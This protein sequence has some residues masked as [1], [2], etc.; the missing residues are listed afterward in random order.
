MLRDE[1]APTSQYD[2]KVLSDYYVNGRRYS[3]T[4]KH[5]GFAHF[6]FGVSEKSFLDCFP[7]YVHENLVCEFCSAC[8]LSK[9]V[10]RDSALSA[11]PIELTIKSENLQKVG[12]VVGGGSTSEGAS[13]LGAVVT[14]EGYKVSFPFCV[15]C[16]HQPS[17]FCECKCCKGIE[18]INK[19]KLSGIYSRSL[20]RL[21]DY[22]YALLSPIELMHISAVLVVIAKA[23]PLKDVSYPRTPL[24][25]LEI[26]V[27]AGILERSIGW[28]ENALTMRNTYEY[29]FDSSQL[30][31]SARR[32]NVAEAELVKALDTSSDS[33][34]SK[35]FR[36][37][38]KELW[39]ELA[40]DY[41]NF[42]LERNLKNDEIEFYMTSSFE[43]EIENKILTIGLS[44]AYQ[45]VLD[46]LAN[47]SC[48]RQAIDDNVKGFASV[49]SMLFL[50]MRGLDF[51]KTPVSKFR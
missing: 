29:S 15:N 28:S 6:S 22:N 30:R 17:K 40:L 3:D 1:S 23:A 13:T 20:E 48:S 12:S 24:N 26:L 49:F 8:L 41:L 50:E 45:Y 5:H 18:S 35:R 31:Y 39:C 36:N 19:A 21:F 10:S 51:F 33:T 44:S 14:E 2:A 42:E 47:K 4:E 32:S 27:K 25:C 9:F 46:Q 37:Q 38:I 34:F 7:N 43:N 11:S 16:S